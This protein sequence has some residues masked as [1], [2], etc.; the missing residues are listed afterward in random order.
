MKPSASQNHAEQQLQDLQIHLPP[1]PT[2][3]GAYV[4][5]VQAGNLLFLSGMLPVVGKEVKYV[6]Q[7]G[8]ELSIE[9]GRRAA[10]IASLNALATARHL[11]GSLDKV[12]K[13]V[14]LGI[15]ISTS[16]DFKEH[17]KVADGASELFESIFGK[18][19]ASTRI[20]V[21]A[22]SLPLGAA[23]LLEVILE[24]E[25]ARLEGAT[26]TSDIDGHQVTV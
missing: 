10:H 24:V 4:E 22:A 1:A 13:V 19:R 12:T 15:S 7:V 2:P 17:P 16:R 18:E 21:G 14:R 26:E 8:A 6:G 3:F 23:V 20:V 5:A 9:E 25:P 11:L